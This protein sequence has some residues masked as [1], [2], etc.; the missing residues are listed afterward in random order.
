RVAEYTRL[1]GLDN[2][3]HKYPHQLSGGMQQ[4]ASIA[5]A[6]A[7]E[8]SV[9]LMDE[10]FASLDAHTRMAM[11][12]EVVRIWQET[13]KTIVFVTHSVEEALSVG[14]RVIVSA[15]HPASVAYDHVIELPRPR[16]RTSPAFNS[17][18]REILGQLDS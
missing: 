3:L 11:Q 5:R 10:P 2:A 14:S 13:G 6:L 17:L 16:D 8:P 1:V 18:K 12:D 7:L 4:R 9:L 15:G